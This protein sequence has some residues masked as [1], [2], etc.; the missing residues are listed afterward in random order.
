[1]SYIWGEGEGEGG[2]GKGGPN[3]IGK[4][5]MWKIRTSDLRSL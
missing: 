3:N 5:I 2:R 1:M 4:V